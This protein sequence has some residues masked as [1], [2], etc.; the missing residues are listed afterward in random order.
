M[1]TQQFI[2][3]PEDARQILIDTAESILNELWNMGI[4]R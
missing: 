3:L 1:T 4:L 2:D